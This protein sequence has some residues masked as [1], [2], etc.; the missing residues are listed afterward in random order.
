MND[1]SHF[2]GC[3]IG[4]EYYRYAAYHMR[5][6]VTILKSIFWNF[7][8]RSAFI[9]HMNF[10]W[11]TMAHSNLFGLEAPTVKFFLFKNRS[12]QKTTKMCNFLGNL[13]CMCS[14]TCEDFS[15]FTSN[16]I[17]CE[18]FLR[19]HQLYELVYPFNGVCGLTQ[20]VVEFMSFYSF[21]W[22]TF[23]IL[24]MELFQTCLVFFRSFF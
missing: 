9:P 8:V 24:A 6:D 10:S 17:F 15:K 19:S 16:F 2:Y 7:S 14:C 23:L 22:P 5:N 20:F 18:L 21:F 3:T 13:T 4:W 1:F 11:Q 12:N